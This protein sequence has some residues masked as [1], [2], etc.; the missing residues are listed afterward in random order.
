M[1]RG[2]GR[3]GV[4][5][6]IHILTQCF[7][8]LSTGTSKRR[9]LRTAVRET[10]GGLLGAALT[11]I[12]GFRAFTLAGQ[13]FLQDMGLLAALGIAWCCV[14]CVTLL[15][16]LLMCLPTSPPRPPPR[17]LGIPSY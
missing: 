10:G 2:A 14:L 13:S 12:A 16:A 17:A 8:A 11:T 1:C 7:A 3:L 15:P 9:A 4:D 6:T 5:Y